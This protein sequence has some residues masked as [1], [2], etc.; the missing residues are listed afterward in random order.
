MCGYGA[1]DVHKVL[2]DCSYEGPLCY[3]DPN[4]DGGYGGHL[5]DIQV[6]QLD[7]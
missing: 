1:T 3:R 6:C 5:M 7:N 2:T 4:I